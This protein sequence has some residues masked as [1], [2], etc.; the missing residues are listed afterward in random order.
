MKTY[1]QNLPR[2]TAHQ[3]VLLKLLTK[4]RFKQRFTAYARSLIVKGAPALIV[5]LKL[6]IYGDAEKTL[7]VEEVLLEH[8]ASMEKNSTLSGETEE[9]DPTVLLW[10]NYFTSQHFYFRRDFETALKYIEAAIEHTP[11]VVDLYVLKAKIYKRG[12]NALKASILYDEARKLDLAD[13]YLN[14]VASRYK[15]RVDQVKEAEE[16]MALFSKDSGEDKGLN[17]H[18]MQCMWYE[19]ECGNAYNRKGQLRLALKNFNYIERHFETIYEDQ[20][21]FHLYAV[22]KFTL[23][24]YFEMIAMEDRVYQNKFAVK[25]ALGMIKVASKAAKLNAAEETKA[26]QPEV[27]EFKASKEYH[28]LLEDIKKSDD[29]DFKFDPDPKGYDLYLKFVSIHYHDSYY[30]AVI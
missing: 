14:A 26:L 7:I 30:F 18:D 15:I 3:R 8:I 17:V 25:A 19:V 10:L 12:G 6:D 28:Q 24:A 2:A 5:D 29:D 20:F 27:T 1:E 4:D 11:T 21:D 16:T 22:R 9:Q 23:S 13:R